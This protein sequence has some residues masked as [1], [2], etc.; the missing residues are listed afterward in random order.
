M[1]AEGDDEISVETRLTKGDKIPTAAED[2]DK[3]NLLTLTGET[4][5]SAKAH[6]AEVTKE[7]VAQ[8]IGTITELN[9]QIKTNNDRFA[10]LEKQLESAMRALATA[11][12]KY[13]SK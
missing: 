4:R 8:Y 1:V 9:S 2:A 5:E 7:V 10:A 13:G 6:T 12:D 3:S 11:A